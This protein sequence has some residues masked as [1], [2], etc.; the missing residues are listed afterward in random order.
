[1][2]AAPAFVAARADTLSARNFARLAQ[3]VYEVV[4]IKLADPKKTMVEGRLRRRLQAVG[5]DT[6]DAYCD[7]LFG[8]TLA[9]T[10]IPLLINAVTTNKTD[11]FREPDHFDFL[12]E[13]AL[14][15]LFEQG[16]RSLRC[17]SAACSIGAEP[18]TLAMVL[19]DHAGRHGGFDFDILA[20]DIDTDVL[21]TARRGIYPADMLAP[22]PAALQRAYVRLPTDHRRREVRIAPELRSMVGFARLNLMDESYPVSEPMHLIF[23]RNVLIYFDKPTQRAVVTRLLDCLAPNGYLFLGHSESIHGMGLPLMP[24]GSTVFQRRQA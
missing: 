21:A 8:G 20:T 7:A 24:V 3:Y 5:I 14:P 9:A 2:T 4:G 13:T 18:Y 16:V 19:D 17:W 23:C 12:L 15:A 11:F 10:E 6:L 22:V 1:M